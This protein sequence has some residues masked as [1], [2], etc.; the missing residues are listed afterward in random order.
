[1]VKACCTI[2]LCVWATTALAQQQHLS[3]VVVGVI[4]GDTVD[5][6]TDSPRLLYRI[7]IAEVDAPE[8]GQPHG[9]A[10]KQ[11]VSNW[12]FRKVATVHVVDLDRRDRIVGHLYC[13]GMS[14]SHLLVA[15]GMA[16]W[17]VD[18]STDLRLRNTEVYARTRKKGLW[19]DER[20]IPPWVWRQVRRGG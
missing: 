13:E 8:M 5:L 2:L 10:A 16:W 14:M 3:G 4:D 17:Y 15:E 20:P 19:I 12:C 18:Y 1:V 7:R 9:R 11:F 6:L